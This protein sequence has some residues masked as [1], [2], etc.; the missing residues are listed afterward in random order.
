MPAKSKQNKRHI[1]FIY[2]HHSSIERW[3][4]LIEVINRYGT[5]IVPDLPGFGGM[6]SFRNINKKPT[7]D[8]FADYLADFIDQKID[9]SKITIVGLSFGFLVVTRMLQKRPDLVDKV[10]LLVS[11]A[12]FS[13]KKDFNFTLTRYY[14]YRL[15]T[16]IFSYSLTA[17]FYK[18][19][20][21]RPLII[22][23]IY[24][25]SFNAKD[26]FAGLSEAKLIA[27]TQ[28]EIK[29]W[30]LND[31]LTHMSTNREMLT[32]NNTHTK[33]NMPVWHVYPD[34]DRYFNHEQVINSFISIFSEVHPILSEHKGHAPS[35]IAD[36][37]EADSMIPQ[38]LK[39]LLSKI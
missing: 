4:G 20:F 32:V 8:N 16:R 38:S 9:Q 25:K 26:K 34:Q 30:Q 22:K 24:K 31:M 27:T 17:S 15:G 37:D 12:G 13:N 19:I 39:K 11:V 5:V 7:L 18:F 14:G 1:L 21:T 33:I 29:L 10:E 28:A 35:I 23:T 3:S 6:E 36:A 2:G